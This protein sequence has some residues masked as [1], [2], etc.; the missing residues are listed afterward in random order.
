MATASYKD[1][2]AQIEKLT[3]QAE[4]ARAKE[5]EGVV[6]QIQAMMS[7]YGIT[8]ADLGIKA[9]RGKRKAAVPS[10]AKFQ[11]PETGAT[12]TGRGRAPAWIA[13]KDRSKYQV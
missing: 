3:K 13:G 2:T 5:V 4:A 6:T 7:E 9:T 11:D 10:A 8:G 1:L 12:W